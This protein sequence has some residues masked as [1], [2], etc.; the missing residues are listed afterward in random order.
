MTLITVSRV[1]TM[2]Q[3]RRDPVAFVRSVIG[4]VPDAWQVEVLRAVAA[5]RRVALK[6]SKG[7]GKST[8][9][10]WIGWWWICTRAHSKTVAVSITSENLRDNLWAEF[11]KWLHR[12]PLLA[13]QFDWAAE[14]ITNKQYP[15]TWWISARAFSKTAD[16]QQQAN[17][18]AGVHADDVA[19][20]VDEAGDIPDAVVAAAEAGL[21]NVD[22]AAQRDARLIVAGNPTQLGGPLYRACTT[23][24]NLWWVKE[25]SGDPDDPNRAPRVSAQWAREQIQKY[26][27]DNPWV[28]VNVFGQFPPGQSNT[29]IALEDVEAA[30][31]REIAAG[32]Y[33]NEARILGVDVARFGDD[34]SVILA[35]QGRCVFTPEILRNVDTMMLVGRVTETINRWRPH[36]VFVDVTGVGAGVVDRLHQ[37]GFEVIG[38]EA[39]GKASTPRYLNKRAEMWANMADWVKGATLPDLPEWRAELPTPTYKYVSDNKLQLESKADL[40]KRGLPSP[41]M[42]DALALTFAFPVRHETRELYARAQAPNVQAVTDYDPYA[43]EA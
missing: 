22:D 25:I 28:L 5:N 10:A 35:R 7:P 31:R 43:Q 29:L 15:E 6:A 16:P 41:D 33:Y 8:L 42:A 4:A 39:G 34:R 11:A 26:G 23:E 24:R 17:T 13:S 18:L 3:W 12:S 20:L 40:K 9:L 38:V 14:R 32:D 36:A 2:R 1:E 21:A 27:R 30:C 37:L 19:F